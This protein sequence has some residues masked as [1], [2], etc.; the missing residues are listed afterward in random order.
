[1]TTYAVHHLGPLEEPV[2][3]GLILSRLLCERRAATVDELFVVC[4]GYRCDH[5]LGVII[6]LLMT[7]RIRPTALVDATTGIG[8]LHDRAWS[9]LMDDLT[10]GGIRAGQQL[11]A[12]EA[13]NAW[14]E[15]QGMRV[16]LEH[17]EA[18]CRQLQEVLP[19]LGRQHR[20]RAARR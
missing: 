7:E 15:T 12:T 6:H 11:A 14:C 3:E 20:R 17:I 5:V 8:V 4:P 9:R 16:A 19:R 2:I 13:G 18:S 10:D 1:M